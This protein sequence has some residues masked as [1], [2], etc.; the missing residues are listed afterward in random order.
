MSKENSEKGLF[1]EKQVRAMLEELFPGKTFLGKHI[2]IHTPLFNIECK[3]TGKYHAE[4]HQGL[5]QCED[6]TKESLNSKEKIPICICQVGDDP[7]AVAMRY[8][9]FKELVLKLLN[10]KN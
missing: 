1:F 10:G 8:E 7:P 3:K 9:Y 2:D 5:I 6:N 4:L